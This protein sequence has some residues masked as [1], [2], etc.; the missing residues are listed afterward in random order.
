MEGSSSIDTQVVN[1]YLSIV[2]PKRDVTLSLSIAV[3]PKTLSLSI[4]RE[5]PAK[6]LKLST[7]IC[8]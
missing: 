6:I 4:W 8:P 2:I 7:V 3:H 1:S 5:V